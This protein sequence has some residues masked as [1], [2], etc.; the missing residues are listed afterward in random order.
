VRG[1]D[2]ELLEVVHAPHAGSTDH[3][4]QI[5]RGIEVHY[6]DRC[7]ICLSPEPTSAEHLPP[8]ALGGRS[9][10]RT[11]TRCNNDLGRVEAELTD[12]R[13]NA[14]RHTTATADGIVGARKLP[15]LLHR[16]TADGKFALII[17]G[18]MHPDAEPMLKGPEFALQFVPPNPRLYKL[19]ALK[20]AYLAACLD[21]RA[22]PQTL[23]AD[24]IRRDLLAA[25]DAPSRREIPPSEYALSQQPGGIPAQR[26]SRTLRRL[27]IRMAS[28]S[29]TAIPG[30][31]AST[32]YR[33]IPLSTFAM[34]MNL[35]VPPV[36]GAGVSNGTGRTGTSAVC[37]LAGREGAHRRGGAE[38]AGGVQAVELPTPAPARPRRR[39]QRGGS[40]HDGRRAAFVGRPL[41]PR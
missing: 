12:W 24:V 4:F 18:P 2:G 20:H 9:M 13:D 15:R 14:F 21:L 6:F 37:P 17:D 41:W 16:R 3:R 7:P 1:D 28:A 8:G 30:P 40:R 36:S 29:T 38:P 32:A 27:A 33:L 19:A 22:I 35:A 25:R 11:C 26:P 39:E 31:A 10:T 23:C 34:A 5:V